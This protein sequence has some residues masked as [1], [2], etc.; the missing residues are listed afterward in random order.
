MM[1]FS[2]SLIPES[3]SAHLTLFLN[4]Q[5][6]QRF[7]LYLRLN[8]SYLSCQV[9]ECLTFG[10]DYEEGH[11]LVLFHDKRERSV[12]QKIALQQ[13][14]TRSAFEQA[15]NETHL[16]SNALLCK[17]LLNVICDFSKCL[18]LHFEPSLW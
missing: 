13:V 2:K 1:K 6:E 15:L 16:A 18:N 7:E 8:G 5:D 3:A 11:W 14:G 10:C 9:K 12:S 17:E 4:D